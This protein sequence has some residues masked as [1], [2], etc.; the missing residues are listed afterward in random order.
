MSNIKVENLV[1]RFEST[2]AVD[3]VSF[4]VG[5]GEVFGFL[6]PNGAGKS[7]TINILCTLLSATSG[8]AEVAGFDCASSPD[9][10][11]QAIG[12]IFQD[13]TLDNGLTAY[14]NLLF[15]AYLYDLDRVTARRRIAEVLALV[16]LTAR[17]DDL[18]RK[19]SGGMKRRLEIARGLLHY[20]KV[21]FMDEPTLGLDPQ[22]RNMIWEFIRTLK[23]DT[24]I[25]I[26]MT[27]HYLEEAESC[28]RVAIIDLG[29]VIAI[30]S[31]AEL[32][33]GLRGDT[34]RLV[35]KDNDALAAEVRER[36]GMDAKVSEG[37]VTLTV[38]RGEE[39]LPALIKTI[40]AEI[41]SVNLTK[42]SLN[43]VFLALTGKSIRDEEADPNNVMRAMARSSKK[44]GH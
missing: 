7:T 8:R 27:T 36:F 19:F 1:K 29:K 15:H 5:P 38:E 6:G 3:G 43:D 14:E 18:V 9:E 2:A 10:V 28:D 16:D 11:R 30:G 32:K 21:L 22:S 40:R 44:R 41:T 24:G 4:T 42:P 39:F 34:I 20:P 31:P 35:A 17:K 13:P 33:A 26:F 12:I 23:A 25:T 37:A